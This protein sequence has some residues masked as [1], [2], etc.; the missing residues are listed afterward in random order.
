MRRQLIYEGVDSAEAV[1][2][3]DRGRKKKTLSIFI[4]SFFLHMYTLLFVRSLSLLLLSPA[5]SPVLPPA[6]LLMLMLVLIIM[7]MW[8][9]I[10][11]LMS[12]Y[13]P[14]KLV[15]RLHTRTRPLLFTFTLPFHS[16]FSIHCFFFPFLN[17]HPSFFRASFPFPL[18]GLF[19]AA[20]SRFTFRFFYRCCFSISPWWHRHN[21]ADVV[22]VLKLQLEILKKGSF[23]W[24]L[25]RFDLFAGQFCSEK[26]VYVVSVL[27]SSLSLFPS[28]LHRVFSPLLPLSLLSLLS[29]WNVCCPILTEQCD[30][31][32]E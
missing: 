18:T 32:R 26:L 14:V 24:K 28:L 17:S 7:L 13:Q 6:V 10:A 11:M 1:N 4:H 2:S 5:L 30:T 15:D 27:L 20:I 3:C 8:L 23:R 19:L 22:H 16:W 21:G 29:P 9:L 31:D 25:T 12:L